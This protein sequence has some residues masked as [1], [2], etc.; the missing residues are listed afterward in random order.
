MTTTS[1]KPRKQRNWLRDMPL[2]LR[3][4]QFNAK[5]EKNLSEQH[6]VKRLPIRVNDHV[7]VTSGQ[8]K[9]LEGKVLGIDKKS[10]KITIEEITKEKADGSLHYYPIH[11]SKV[12]I[13]KLVDLDKRRQQMIERRKISTRVAAME[14]AAA[15]EAKAAGKKK[16]K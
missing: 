2:H 9:D 3:G 7:R 15:A 12:I 16:G 11:P 10:Y 13:T 4:T 14:R 1:K 6:D 8:F 5:L